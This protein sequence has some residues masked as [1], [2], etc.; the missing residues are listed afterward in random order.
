MITKSKSLT[1]K[2]KISRLLKELPDNITYEDVQ[3]HLYVLQKI[4]RGLMESKSG[5]GYSTSEMKTKLGKWIKK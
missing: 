5:K 3:Y 1:P 4:E 2:K